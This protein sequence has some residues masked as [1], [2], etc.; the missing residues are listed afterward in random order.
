MVEPLS[1]TVIGILSAPGPYAAGIAWLDGNLWNVD[2]QTRQVYRL[3]IRGEQKYS[4][5]DTRAGPRGVSLGAQHYGPQDVTD[6]VLNVAIPPELPN[7]KLLSEVQYS[8]TPTGMDADRWGQR[9]ALFELGDVDAGGKAVLTYNVQAEVSAIRYLI[10]PEDVGT[11]AD[12]PADIREKYTVDGS[13]YRIDSPYIRETV[14]KAVG[15]EQNPY[16]IA[17]KIYDLLSPM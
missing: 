11:L 17:R 9:C 3:S 5:S 14:K 10:I 12:I 7:Q 15:D 8:V 13:R 4:L 2:F 6:V 16:W 1:G